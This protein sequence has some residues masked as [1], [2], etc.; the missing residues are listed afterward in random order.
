MNLRLQMMANVIFDFLIGLIPLVGDFINIMYKANLRNFV[1]L[2]KH[3]V[4]NATSTGVPKPTQAV[5]AVNEP[6]VKQSNYKTPPHEAAATDTGVYT[7]H[8]MV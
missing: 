5:G 4:E 1:L 2:E 6:P 8:D 7:R 3:L